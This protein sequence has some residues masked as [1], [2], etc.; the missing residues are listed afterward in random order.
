MSAL[1]KFGPWALVALAAIGWVRSYGNDRAATALAVARAD[2]IAWALER[3]DSLEITADSLRQEL[4]DSVVARDLERDSLVGVASSADRRSRANL[5]RLAAILADTAT[6]AAIPDTVRVIVIEAV[7]AVEAQRDV[8]FE[9]LS[10]CAAT[11]LLLEARIR[12]DSTSLNEKDEL[13]VAFDAQLEDAIANRR[14]GCGLVCWSTRAAALYGIVELVAKFAG[15][16][17]GS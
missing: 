14:R 8:C 10:I 1:L 5:G 13:L 12:V 15:G 9:Q 3:H 7:E 6:A 2:S 16:D 11:R 4:S 17:G